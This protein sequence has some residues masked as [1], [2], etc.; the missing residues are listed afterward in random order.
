MSRRAMMSTV[1][2]GVCRRQEALEAVALFVSVL[3]KL[4]K[5]HRWH[6]SHPC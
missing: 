3:L 6:G 4:R 5:E 1:F 2:G